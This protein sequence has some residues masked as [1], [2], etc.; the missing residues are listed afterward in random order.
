MPPDCPRESCY[1]LI[2]AAALALLPGNPIFNELRRPIGAEASAPDRHRPSLHSC[3]CSFHLSQKTISKMSLP[4]EQRGKGGG[5]RLSC[6]ATSLQRVPKLPPRPPPSP[7]NTH[8]RS[9]L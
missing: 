8:Y 6:D 1:P 2:P 5:L 3:R 7:G 9:S 4:D